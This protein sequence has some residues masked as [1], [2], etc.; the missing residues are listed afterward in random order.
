MGF[1]T[2][3]D[4]QVYHESEP[5]N[6]GNSPDV[7]DGSNEIIRD[8]LDDKFTPKS[9]ILNQYF[10]DG[11]P[12]SPHRSNHSFSTG[13]NTPLPL[14]TE[15]DYLDS[16]VQSFLTDDGYYINAGQI[17]KDGY[18]ITHA[19][20]LGYI[21]GSDFGDLDTDKTAKLAGDLHLVRVADAYGEVVIHVTDKLTPVQLRQINRLV[22]D[23][24]DE[25]KTV[26][27][28]I[29][30]DDLSTRFDTNDKKEFFQELDKRGWK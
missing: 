15:T 4:G 6:P 18:R 24:Y 25:E 12:I 27:F 14:I 29:G 21:T 3:Y 5:G 22:K 11:I 7:N 23:A 17:T 19:T 26:E 30:T 2:R 13:E 10:P 16:L 20:L 8:E 28:D 9:N 1:K